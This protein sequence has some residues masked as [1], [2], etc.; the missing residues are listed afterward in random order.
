MKS[1]QK[2]RPRETDEPSFFL[3]SD[4]SFSLMLV[5]HVCHPITRNRTNNALLINQYFFI[6]Q[7]CRGQTENLAMYSI[8]KKEIKNFHQPHFGLVIIKQIMIKTVS[9]FCCYGYSLLG[10]T[11]HSLSTLL[12]VHLCY[13]ITNNSAKNV[14]LISQ[15]PFMYKYWMRQIKIL[16]IIYI[17]TRN[18]CHY[19]EIQIFHRPHSNLFIYKLDHGKFI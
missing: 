14:P 12:V 18:M 7:Y 17:P 6:Y 11:S 19:W 15:H 10:V 5:V 16:N 2:K 9:S 13:P 1:P 3:L 8:K 4:F